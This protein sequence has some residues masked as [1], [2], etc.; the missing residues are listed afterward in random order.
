MERWKSALFSPKFQYPVIAVVILVALSAWYYRLAS[1]QSE[2]DINERSLR[3]LAAL[4]E[5]FSSRLKTLDDIGHRKWD[6]SELRGQVPDLEE[7]CGSDVT[8]DPQRRLTV[9]GNNLHLVVDGVPNPATG[10]KPAPSCWT[11]SFDVLMNSLEDSLPKGAFEDLLLANADGRILYQT[12]RSGMKIADLHSLFEDIGPP[13]SKPDKKQDTKPAAPKPASGKDKT[14]TTKGRQTTTT[15]N[16]T[17]RET[18]STGKDDELATRLATSK[19]TDVKLGGDPYKLYT[20]PVS[21]PALL[22]DSTPLNFIV[23]GILSDRAFHAERGLPL[24][25][26]LVTIG[27]FVLLGG[28]GTY[29][30][31]RFRLMGSSEVLKQRTGFVFIF[32]VVFTAILLG[33]LT[34]HLMFSRH[35]PETEAELQRLAARIE[36]NLAAETHAALDMLSGLESFYL[37]QKNSGTR[38]STE[39]AGTTCANYFDD[40]FKFPPKDSD[41]TPEVLKKVGSPEK[42]P[43]FDNAFF[44]GRSGWQEIKL[45]ARSSVTPKVRV[46]NFGVFRHAL[47]SPNASVAQPAPERA[48]LWRFRDRPGEPGFWIE[49]DYANTNGRY[50][51][52]I[53]RPSSKPL[54]T[55]APV[56]IIGTGL[57]SL[58]QPVFPPEYGFAIVD[59]TGR[60]LFHSMAAKNGR[61]NFADACDKGRRLHDLLELRESGVLETSYLGIRHLLRV[62][63]IEA[64]THS[65]WSIIVFRDLTRLGEDHFDAVLSFF[66]LAGSY[67][68]ILVIGGLLAGF[69]KRPPRW[70]WPANGDRP[71]YW[72]LFWVLISVIILNSCLFFQCDGTELWITAW[73]IPVITI[74]FTLL[75]LSSKESI[76][77]LLSAGLLLPA[78]GW[79][80]AVWFRQRGTPAHL[81]MPVPFWLVCLS[82][83]FF[84]LAL[85]SGKP[86]PPS[87][88]FSLAAVYA[89]PATALL[90]GVGFIPAL[91]LFN[92]SALFHKVVAARRS[93]LE[94]AEQL[95]QRRE[96][97]SQAYFGIYGDEDSARGKFLSQR[98]NDET[99]DLYYMDPLIANLA[100]KAASSRQIVLNWS[101]PAANTKIDYKIYRGLAPGSLSE[102][103]ASATASFAD[104][105]LNP[106]TTYYY[107]VQADDKDRD[108][109]PRSAIVFAE[110]PTEQ[111]TQI[112]LLATEVSSN[113]ISLTWSS[114]RPAARYR[115]LRGVA[116]SSLTK[117][118][119]LTATFYADNNLR[120][121]MTYFYAVQG[122]DKRGPPRSAMVS[123]KTLALEPA[124]RPDAGAKLQPHS[125]DP[126]LLFVSSEL[127]PREGGSPRHRSGLSRDNALMWCQDESFP[128]AKLLL[129]VN[130]TA[131]S[132]S[133]EP[134]AAAGDYRRWIVSA[135]PQ[136]VGTG[137]DPW[138][139]LTVVS[140]LAGTVVAFFGLRY[141][142]KRLFVLD[143]RRA[144][145]W[146]A[147]N[148]SRDLDLG[149]WPFGRHAVLLG[150]PRSGKTEA[151]KGRPGID[152]IDLY[153]V[154]AIGD[155]QWGMEPA[156][157]EPEKLVV[158]DHFEH[159]LD[160]PAER[161][162]KLSVLER[163]VYEVKCRI[164][165]VTTVDPLYFLACLARRKGPSPENEG[166]DCL[167]IERWARVLAGF[168]VVQAKNP[169]RIE[170]DRRFALLWQACSDEERV[171]LHQIAKYGWAN[172]LQKPAMTH[173]VLRGLLLHDRRFKVAVK[174][175]AKY[176]GRSF[177][178]AD[179]VIPDEAGSNDSLSA[180]RIVLGVAIIAFFVALAYV[181]GDQMMAYFATG[182]ST[183]TAATRAFAKA[184]GR[185]RGADTVDA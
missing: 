21:V 11:V 81:G 91:R 147:V 16:S 84:F 131:K 153:Y 73:T 17:R 95:E 29:P 177:S 32:Q 44:V 124:P 154:N 167:D 13:E 171:A 41:W 109:A 185:G 51:A 182:V 122:V 145:E 79:L 19:T 136:R 119:D 61:E 144:E 133:E 54:Q 49:P 8:P 176:I 180:L 149:D 138:T 111:G 178:D 12:R 125:L 114:D 181:W 137:S 2:T 162:R 130:G 59:R 143:W 66:F 82:V 34:G 23:C 94:L 55:R 127:V 37:R 7:E 88:R 99:K 116:P 135:L 70:I 129:R 155:P 1:R 151:F 160:K 57:V 9:S 76:I 18:E 38:E 53:S 123:F 24:E 56:A 42:Y 15:E 77:R 157:R 27:I 169:C 139:F 6:R 128:G 146:P 63:P 121:S 105:D 93:Q 4:A 96:H 22:D 67:V 170:G 98:L 30:I 35:R 108:L 107:A 103:G 102:A 115:V 75:K 126:L 90:L 113:R 163:L 158:L 65:D 10:V 69:A 36:D 159:N 87:A 110:T 31:L 26:T 184:K 100:A 141:A 174:G 106:S 148:I 47:P 60:V 64:F 152:Y 52:F 46:C 71:V 3:V 39:V 118:A 48:D 68:A 83:A 74:A 134:A 45:S 104:N 120:A 150:A 161:Q 89:L 97:I 140:I 101:P 28:I 168:Q 112:Q 173:L 179:C 156:A 50:L 117:I 80:I 165:I 86:R 62:Q 40:D 5:Q 172:C 72:R 14:R 58:Y 33:G 20:V 25:N 78:A 183:V 166:G 132:C 142:I 43:Y 85:P 164:V 175:F 92:A